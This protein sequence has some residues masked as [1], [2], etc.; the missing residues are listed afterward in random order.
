MVKGLLHK[1]EISVDD[2]SVGGVG[3]LRVWMNGF[4]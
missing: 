4:L 3:K 2:L 1:I